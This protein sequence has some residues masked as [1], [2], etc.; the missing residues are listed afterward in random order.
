MTQWHPSNDQLI[1]FA[2][3]S[4]SSSMSIAV[5][6]HLHYCKVCQEQVRIAESTAS[7]LFEQQAPIHDMTLDFNALMDKMERDQIK[8]ITKPEPTVGKRFPL[9]VE[10]LMK[11]GI[12][13]L[14]WSSPMKNLRTTRLMEDEN[15]MILGLHHMNAGGRVPHHT[16]RGNEISVVIEGG[17]SD[18]LG[19]YAEGDFIHLGTDHKHSPLAHAD[20]DCWILSIVEAPVKVTGPLGWVI[21]PFLKA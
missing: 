16:H 12:D 19:T 17:F 15:G 5:T 3:G 21:N 18:E 20:G 2:S 6:T 1:E 11:N 13:S 10:K 8:Q 9:V 4:I 7:V 14:N